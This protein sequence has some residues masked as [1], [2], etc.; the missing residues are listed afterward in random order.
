MTRIVPPG[1]VRFVQA[2]VH[3][4]AIHRPRVTLWVWRRA[5]DPALARYIDR[6]RR[7]RRIALDRVVSANGRGIMAGLQAVGLV[8]G[9]GLEAWAADLA[10]LVAL[11]AA[12]AGEKVVRVRLETVAE[13]RERP[14]HIDSKALR[15]LC[16]Y[17]GPGTQWLSNDNVERA[18]LC[19][20]GRSIASVNRGAVKDPGRVHSLRPWWV[21]VLKGETYPGN[22]GNGLVHRPQPAEG[23]GTPRVRLRIDGANGERAGP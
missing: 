12:H 6:A 14:F 15:L 22:A 4:D 9:P 2:P 8:P 10:G 1:H 3:L 19:L 21:A 16:T 23:P 5:P 7:R 13:E 11:F 18:Q 17:A 20:R